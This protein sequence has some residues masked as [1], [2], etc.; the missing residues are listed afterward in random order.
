MSNKEYLHYVNES[1]NYVEI[2]AQNRELEQY[3]KL[4]RFN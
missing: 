4:D 2:E 3:A 1:E